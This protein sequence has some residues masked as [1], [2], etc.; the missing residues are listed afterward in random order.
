MEELIKNII[1]NGL[2]ATTEET[3]KRMC[4]ERLDTI[5]DED[6]IM[7]N[8]YCVVENKLETISDDFL[9]DSFVQAVKERFEIK[10][11][12]YSMDINEIVKEA[13]IAKL[14]E[15]DIGD[16][17]KLLGIKNNESWLLFRLLS[18]V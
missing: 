6:T 4:Q 8:L 11:Y 3:V 1:E 2:K 7:E 13:V 18:M 16:L 17:I 14:Q 10:N 12:L 5:V 9:G 15:M